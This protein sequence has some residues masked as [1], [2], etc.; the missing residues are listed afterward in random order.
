MSTIHVLNRGNDHVLELR[1]LKNEVTGAPL[2]SAT[3]SV[4]LVDSTGAQVTGD[5]WPKTMSHVAGGTYRCTLVYG[6]ALV[7]DGRYTA[8]ITADAG[9]GL[10]ALWDLFVARDRG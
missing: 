4:T 5:T 8:Q 1:G 3:V 2:T 9:P 10:R 7:L 6:L